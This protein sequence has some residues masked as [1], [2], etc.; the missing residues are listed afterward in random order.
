[1]PRKGANSLGIAATLSGTSYLDLDPDPDRGDASPARRTTWQCMRRSDGSPAASGPVA[2]SPSDSGTDVRAD[3]LLARMG[4]AEGDTRRRLAEARTVRDA[5]LAT[6]V[7]EKLAQIDSSVRSARL[8]RATLRR[9]VLYDD[10]TAAQAAWTSLTELE[11]TAHSMAT[12]ATQCV[13]NEGGDR[14]G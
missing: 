6:C 8:K 4:Q 7:A 12:Q 10:A 14:D 1:M 2:L 13:G 11:G 5:A 3:Q 9:A